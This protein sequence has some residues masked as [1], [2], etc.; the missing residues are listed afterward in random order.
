MKFEVSRLPV[1][2]G[3]LWHAGRRHVANEYMTVH[4]LR[5]FDKFTASFSHLMVQDKER[6][7]RA[8]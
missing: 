5:D 3:G 7:C 4:G 8:F 6:A 2:S 1:V